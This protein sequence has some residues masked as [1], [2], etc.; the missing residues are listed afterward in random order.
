MHY[1]SLLRVTGVVGASKKALFLAPVLQGLWADDTA[2][3]V[4]AGLSS[5]SPL[6]GT[7]M[8]DSFFIRSTQK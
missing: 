1:D 7:T 3:S 8:S 4:L 5:N 2:Q 6:K